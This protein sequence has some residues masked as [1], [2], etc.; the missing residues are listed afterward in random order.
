MINSRL[1]SFSYRNWG[2]FFTTYS[3]RV[4][5]IGRVKAILLQL[6]HAVKNT[7]HSSQRDACLRCVTELVIVYTCPC[8]HRCLQ[9]TTARYT[10]VH[11]VLSPFLFRHFNVLL[12]L[13]LLLNVF[14]Y[15]SIYVYSQRRIDPYSNFFRHNLIFKTLTI[16][17][18]VRLAYFRLLRRNLVSSF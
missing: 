6:L 5:Y 3:F 15:I 2:V 4:T 1:E 13:L 14:V 18:C 7:N 8:W 10:C 9:L 16:S 12:L 11:I 17:K